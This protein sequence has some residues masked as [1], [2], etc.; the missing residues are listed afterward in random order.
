LST[1][2]TP[3]KNRAWCRRPL[4][5]QKN[6][7]PSLAMTWSTALSSR[8]SKFASKRTPHK[9]VAARLRPPLQPSRNDGDVK[10]RTRLFHVA[11]SHYRHLPGG[12]GGNGFFKR[13]DALHVQ[14]R[15]S[16]F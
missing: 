7:E 5:S 1:R 9:Q 13:G 12:H 14:H 3:P 15:D 10:D 16:C 4:R 6:I 11:E 8:S 2:S